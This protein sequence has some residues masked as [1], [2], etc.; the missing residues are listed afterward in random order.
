MPESTSQS[1]NSAH[2]AVGFVLMP[3]FTLLPFSAFI[4]AL[5]LAADEGD[6]SRQ[7]NCQWTV[8]GPTLEPISSS[9]GVTVKPWETYRNPADFDYIVVVGGLLDSTLEG[10]EHVVDYLQQAD[11]AHVPIIGL[12]T[13]SFVMI[14]AGLMDQRRCCV[15]WFHYK[16]LTERYANVTP[17]A[18]Q[19]F[20]DDGDRITCAGGAVAADLAAYIIERHLGQSWAR[21][22]LRILVMDNP[23]PAN[24]PQPQPNADYQVDNRWVA[25]AL[26]LMEQNLSRPL[27]SD[28]I[29]SRLSISKRQLERLFINDTGDSLQK[30]YRKIRLR[31]GLWLLQNTDRLIT[32]I[33]QDC[34]FSDTAHFS[35]VFRQAFEKKPTDYRR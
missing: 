12:C 16:D 6:Q 23:R 2:L 10:S 19:L 15:S 14:R 17:I 35:R 33:G 30:F 27:S 8:M 7:I 28:E 32:D 24:A 29:A 34:G 1:L 13:G 26:L 3:S 18:D 4:D 9:A 20:V 22:S 5:R 25:R 11:R 21:K 31:Y